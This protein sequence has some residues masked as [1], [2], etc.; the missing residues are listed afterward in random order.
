MNTTTL[1]KLLQDVFGFQVSCILKEEEKQI[2]I[3]VFQVPM[4]RK[5]SLEMAIYELERTLVPDG[6]VFFSVIAYTLEE[7]KRYYPNLAQAKPFLSYEGVLTYRN[8][9]TL[10]SDVD[11]KTRVSLAA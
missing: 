7:T 5:M 10:G 4:E 1:G 6:N 2:I 3:H 8:E 9:G 11:A